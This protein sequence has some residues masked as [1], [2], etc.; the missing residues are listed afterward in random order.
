MQI[1]CVLL[2]AALLVPGGALSRDEPDALPKSDL[3]IQA[4]PL[5][6]P[7][8]GGR[9]DTTAP[10]IEG[11][12]VAA[13]SPDLAPVITAI[14]SDDLS[15]V[16]QGAI[17]YRLTPDSAYRK[18]PLLPGRG[19]VFVGRLP[20]GTQR[21]GFAYYVEVFDA[22]GNGPARMGSPE[23][24]F[25]VAP[26]TEG[27]SER[28]AREQLRSEIGPVHPAFM[29]LSLGGGILAAAAAGVIWFD[30]GN[31]QGQLESEPPGPRRKE[32]DNAALGN[33]AIGGVLSV[34]AVTALASG[35][36]L[37]VYAAR[38]E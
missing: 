3:D 21:E 10:F 27:T 18:V 22:A 15:G 25:T 13:Q 32:L 23:R 37:L 19:G 16:E 35:I 8:E 36:G 30:Y 14:I 5:P 17:Y 4:L 2:A 29:V 6:A 38:E 26:A 7:S 28:L 24:P 20:D 1:T 33:V 31:V 12:A 9:E 34:I 11:L